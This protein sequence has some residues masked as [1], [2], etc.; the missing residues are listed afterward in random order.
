V[1]ALSAQLRAA[2]KD[3]G[4]SQVDLAAAL[5]YER[6]SDVSRIERGE[7]APRSLDVVDRWAELCGREVHL[8]RVGEVHAVAA[9]VASADD[10]HRALVARLLVALPTLPDALVEGLE[11]DLDLWESRYGSSSA[12]ART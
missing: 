1:P 2:R 12:R 9:A 6:H 10:R 5:G 11:H 4:L 7:Q 8:S 3:A